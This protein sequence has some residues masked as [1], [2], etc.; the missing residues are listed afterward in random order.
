[1]ENCKIILYP[2]HLVRV[3]ESVK[4]VCPKVLQGCEGVIITDKVFKGVNRNQNV[5]LSVHI[6]FKYNSILTKEPG[7]M[8]LYTVALYDLRKCMKEDNH[9]LNNLREIIS[10][11]R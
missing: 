6:S 8:N 4:W 5:H 2:N 11:G 10:K 3:I 7:L 1:M 9:C